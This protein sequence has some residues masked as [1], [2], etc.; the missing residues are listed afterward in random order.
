MNRCPTCGFDT[1]P[2]W[3]YCP[4]CGQPLRW[5]AVAAPAYLEFIGGPE[6]G[7]IAPL[8]GSLM[9]IGRRSDNEVVILT[10]RSISRR[11]AVISYRGRAFWIADLDSTLGTRVGGEKIADEYPLSDGDVILIGHTRLVFCQG[12]PIAPKPRLHRIALEAR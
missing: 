12:E 8:T 9:T 2:A 10:D 11:H 4:D 3:H 5:I 1:D 7:R 6:D